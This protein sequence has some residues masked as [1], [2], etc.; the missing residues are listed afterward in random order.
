MPIGVAMKT[1]GTEFWKFY[2]KGTFFQK[3]RKH[4]LQNCKTMRLQ[5]GITTQWLQ[6]ARNSLP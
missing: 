3:K 2:R 4:F 5:T 6:I 1:F